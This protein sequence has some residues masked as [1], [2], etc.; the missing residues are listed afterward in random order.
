M[1]PGGG[2]AGNSVGDYYRDY[3][4]EINAALHKKLL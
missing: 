2:K 4:I 1:G 3:G